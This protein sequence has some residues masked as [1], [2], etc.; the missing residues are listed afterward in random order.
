[1]MFRDSVNLSATYMHGS[2]QTYYRLENHFGRTQW[3]S[4]MKWVKW[5]PIAVHL[6]VVLILMQDRYMVCSEC[7]IGS[8]IILG[9]PNGTRR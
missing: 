1:V 5:K 2:R 3:Y 7:G 4:Y 6:E 8:E 9:A